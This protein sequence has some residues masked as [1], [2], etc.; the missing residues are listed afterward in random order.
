MPAG[1]VPWLLQ[2]AGLGELAWISKRF[3]AASAESGSSVSAA[4]S[5]VNTAPARASGSFFCTVMGLFR[6]GGPLGRSLV[7]G[8]LRSR[9]VY[10]QLRLRLDAA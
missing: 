3:T 8:V 2:A 9:R 5:V 4:A 6:W 7:V 10:G 1:T